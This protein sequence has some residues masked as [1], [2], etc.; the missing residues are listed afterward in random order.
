M[1]DFPPI[2]IRRP[3]AP[4]R[5]G[6]TIAEM[7]LS[8]ALAGVFTAVAIPTLIGIG[9]QR[10]RIVRQYW[11]LNEVSNVL[12]SLTQCPLNDVTQHSE[13]WQKR[14]NKRSR[15]ILP[16]AKFTITTT[17]ISSERISGLAIT[18]RL[19]WA[20]THSPLP[21]SIVLTGWNLEPSGATP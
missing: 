20:A 17:P 21:Q 6:F 19:E 13:D 16:Q 5:R 8:L 4:D 10:Q 12:D 18:C 2:F 7:T 15:G 1:P 14:V 3:T 9:Q 11:A